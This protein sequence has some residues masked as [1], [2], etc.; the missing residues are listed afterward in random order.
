MVYPIFASMKIADKIHIDYAVLRPEEQIPEHTQ[1]T[2]ELAYVIAGCG[3]R[4]IGDTTESFSEGEVI[5]IPPGMNHVWTFDAAYTDNEGNIADIALFISPSFLNDIAVTLPDFARIINSIIIRN[6]AVKFE[7]NRKQMIQELMLR[8]SKTD[9][10][11]KKVLHFLSLISLIGTEI[12]EESVVGRKIETS[13]TKRKVEQVR[14]YCECN[15]MRRIKL[16]DA[17]NHIGMNVSS[18]CKFFLK[19]FG[20]TFTEYINRLRVNESCRRLRN[21]SDSVSEIA[22]SVGFTSVPYFNRIFYRHNK[23]TPS[24]YREANY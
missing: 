1:D 9:A 6:D 7:G 11:E 22:Y 12:Y 21:S 2:W 8:L 3:V 19:N 18:F 4:T 20:C 24:R 17:A 23:C 16:G 10:P 13:P 15:Y 5:L 14:I